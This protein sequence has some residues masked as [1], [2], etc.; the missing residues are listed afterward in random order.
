MTVA[1]VGFHGTGKSTYLGA[2]W[3]IL[4]DPRDETMTEVELRGD[5]SHLQFIGE[6]VARA[7]RLTRTDV[8][9]DEGFFVTLQFSDGPVL[10]LKV[11]D[12]SG[13]GARVLVE[14]RLWHPQI[15]AAVAAADA[16]VLFLSPTSLRL[17]IRSSFTDEI[18]AEFLL[19]SDDGLPGES[20]SDGSTGGGEVVVTGKTEEAEP[21]AVSATAEV[22]GADPEESEEVE[23]HLRLACTAA[24]TID[25]LENILAIRPEGTPLRIG[26]VI[27]AWDAVD[28]S[29][30]PSS[31]L[32][33]RLPAV[34]SFLDMNGDRLSV[35]VFGVSGQGGRL[36]EQKEELLKK[37]SVLD[38]AYARDRAGASVAFSDPLRWAV[39]D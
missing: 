1:F 18:L 12:L 35:E 13:E 27:S 16:I 31:W 39:A 30:T 19:Q 38:R 9:S 23:F 29:L 2:L 22:D 14:D 8:E 7:E 20:S 36:P 21:A 37:G 26:V 3:M 17:P 33:Q 4:Q 25:A 11:P 15:S 24:K 28:D 6:Q 10:R 32:Q 5:R 34:A